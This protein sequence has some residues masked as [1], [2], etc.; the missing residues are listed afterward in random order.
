MAG[1][2]PNE[3]SRASILL[4]YVRAEMVNAGDCLS[5]EDTLKL[6]GVEA[7]I[8]EAS[9]LLSGVVNVVNKRLHRDGDWRHLS[10]VEMVGYRIATPAELRLETMARL[11]R[12][13]RQQVATQRAIEKVIRHP[14][15]TTAEQRRATDAAAAQAPLLMIQRRELQKIRRLWPTEETSPVSDESDA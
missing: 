15:A 3:N 8:H 14:D 11:R 12:S 6:V 7:D 10:T 5:Y 13:E 4:D 2:L 1:F 9:Q